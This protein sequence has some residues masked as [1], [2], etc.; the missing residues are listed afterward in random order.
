M[1]AEEALREICELLDLYPVSTPQQVVDT[2]SSMRSNARAVEYDNIRLRVELSRFQRLKVARD[3][4]NGTVNTI[5]SSRVRQE[6]TSESRPQ[7][8]SMM[9]DV[10]T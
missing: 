8:D 4:V 5:T 2:I 9:E 6:P 3:M 1:T 10:E 7:V